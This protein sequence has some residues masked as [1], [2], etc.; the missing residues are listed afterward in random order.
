M[1]GYH[2]RVCKGTRKG[3]PRALGKYMRD[4]SSVDDEWVWCGVV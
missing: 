2:V 3:Q 4:M 1:L